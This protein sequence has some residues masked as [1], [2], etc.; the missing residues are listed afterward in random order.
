MEDHFHRRTY[1]RKI[2]SSEGDKMLKKSLLQLGMTFFLASA[3][4]ASAAGIMGTSQS[5]STSAYCK[6]YTCNLISKKDRMWMYRNKYGDLVGIIR[7]SSDPGSRVVASMV[8]ID[9]PTSDY[10]EDDKKMINTLQVVLYGK[11]ISS[12]P[13]QCYYS[14]DG[15]IFAEFQNMG[16]KKRFGC[17]IIDD[18]S[19][20]ML[21][22]SL[23]GDQQIKF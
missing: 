20:R 7:Q 16:M 5:F 15:Y 13:M 23:G 8:V 17:G 1:T 18:G 9:S 11:V 10:F 6:T 12:F 21:L 14:E 22:V 19:K 4:L 2:R 3:A